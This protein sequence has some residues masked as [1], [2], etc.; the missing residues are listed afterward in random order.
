[1]AHLSLV[2]KGPTTAQKR[3]QLSLLDEREAAVLTLSKRL[4]ETDVEHLDLAQ[5]GLVLGKE[6]RELE[7]L[8]SEGKGGAHDVGS[9]IARIVFWHQAR[10]QVDAH[11]GRLTLV[12]ILDERGE[13]SGERL[14]EPCPEETVDNERIG[15]E[16]GRV[17]VYL[18]LD[19]FFHLDAFD[20][21]L[22]V[23]GTVGREVIVD[24]E[25]IDRHGK[26]ALGQ[27]ARHSE[28]ITAIIT[29][30]GKDDYPHGHPAPGYLIGHCRRRAFHQVDALHG[31]VFDGISVPLLYLSA[32]KYFHTLQKYE[33]MTNY[34]SCFPIFFVILPRNY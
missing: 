27:Q 7:L 2:G 15:I 26:T 18:D 30:S 32:R 23:G 19:K 20:Q 28:G 1:M 4:G 9:D 16:H 10:R 31:L 5:I 12:D 17:E 22:L 25:E 34:R 29:G 13:T 6:H 11:H 8:E 21:P 33:K 24:V 3:A 14:V